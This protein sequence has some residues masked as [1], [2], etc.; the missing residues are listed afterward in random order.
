M[1][2]LLIAFICIFTLISGFSQVDINVEKDNM[3]IQR[4]QAKIT[5][6][7]DVTPEEVR[8]YFNGLKESYSLWIL[9]NKESSLFL[10]TSKKNFFVPVNKL[11]R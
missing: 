8:L 4:E 3:L 1:K 7:V 2:K 9:C 11:L 6:K 5:E 10:T